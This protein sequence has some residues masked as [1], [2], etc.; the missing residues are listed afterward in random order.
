MKK[1]I[2]K[3]LF[4]WNSIIS[5]IV[6]IVVFL[7][8]FIFYYISS[9]K[10]LGKI[11]KNTNSLIKCSQSICD[12]FNFVNY[13]KEDTSDFI[14]RDNGFVIEF[15]DEFINSR[16]PFNFSDINFLKNFLDKPKEYEAI[17]KEKWLLYTRES[18]LNNNK[19]FI[20]TGVGLD[21]PWRIF[22]VNSSEIAKYLIEESDRL[23]KNIKSEEDLSK[24]RTRADIIQ[25][26]RNDG[27]VIEWGW[28]APG[29]IPRNKL[30]EIS[31]LSKIKIEKSKLL[32]IE[33]L[34]EQGNFYISIKMIDLLPIWFYLV[35]VYLILWIMIIFFMK[36]F[37][38][39]MLL[40]KEVPDVSLREAISKGETEIVEF[41][42]FKSLDQS[43]TLLKSVVSLANY[44]G[45]VIF[46]GVEDNGEIK[47]L[48][49]K[50]LKELDETK[51]KISQFIRDSITPIPFV[52][53]EEI[54]LDKNKSKI[55]IKMKVAPFYE[56]LYSLNSIFYRR[57]GTTDIPM[58]FLYLKQIISKLR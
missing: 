46:L 26:V 6:L 10:E 54:F 30:D 21:I 7:L 56:S 31:K 32:I 22:K 27:K 33:K 35:I 55:I 43:L 25:V 50:N 29:F 14:I 45:G 13:P 12:I 4:F 20:M 24:I 38:L 57:L 36:N 51:N 58:D 39:K 41:K 44:K 2:F 37:I 16:L 8:G 34:F 1:K 48:E 52:E 42:S 40:I 53:F 18:N 9:I 3:Q 15:S 47:P 28:S 23:I 5:L 11:N 49:I 19:Y 17:T